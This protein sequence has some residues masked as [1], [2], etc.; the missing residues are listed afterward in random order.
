[1]AVSH[2]I[3]VIELFGLQLGTR[4]FESLLS[5]LSNSMSAEHLD[6]LSGCNCATSLI[7]TMAS[8]V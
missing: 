4:W 2:Y 5:A 7:G 3:K 6:T 8:D 1:M